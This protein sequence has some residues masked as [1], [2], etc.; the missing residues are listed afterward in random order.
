[1]K[2]WFNYA[3]CQYAA[4]FSLR[5]PKWHVVVCFGSLSPVPA[6][7]FVCVN[8][9]DTVFTY[10]C[11]C[12]HLVLF[13]QHTTCHLFGPKKNRWFF[14]SILLV[15]FGSVFQLTWTTFV[16]VADMDI[17]FTFK[18][19][20]TPPV[21]FWQHTTC[22]VFGPQKNC[23]FLTMSTTCLLVFVCPV[24]ELGGGLNWNGFIPKFNK[25]LSNH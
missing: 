14:D 20:C 9:M 11:Y 8:D 3:A 4:R 15:Y 17:I 5:R 22:H 12:T 16:P 10:T 1:M 6:P 18:C 21:L 24:P 13:L 7:L 19:F 23:W 2:G 25:Y